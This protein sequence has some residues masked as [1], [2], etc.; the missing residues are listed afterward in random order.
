[1]VYSITVA[2]SFFCPLIAF[3]SVGGTMKAV[4]GYYYSFSTDVPLATG[5]VSS[6]FGG[7]WNEAFPKSL[8]TVS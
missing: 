6:S 5:V 7:N 4:F 3:S 8:P 2:N 1:V